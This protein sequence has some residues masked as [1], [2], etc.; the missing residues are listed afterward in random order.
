MS[1]SSLTLRVLM[2]ASMSALPERTA[3]ILRAIVGQYIARAA[4]VPS[5]SIARVAGLDVSS[6]TIR[7]EMARLEKDG[8][9][10]RPHTSAGSVPSDRG[11][12]FYVESLEDVELPLVQR[13][14]VEHVLHQVE[15][16]LEEWLSLTATLLANLVS[17]LAIVFVARP[18]KSRFKHLE[19]VSLQDDTALLVM[20]LHGAKVRQQLLTFPEPVTQ[21]ELTAM[22]ARLNQRL[23]GK[24]AEQI[25]GGS[26]LP[27]AEGHVLALVE[28]IMEAEDRRELGESY[29]DG[30]H[31]MLEQPEF[32]RG[33]RALTLVELVEQRNL[34]RDI[35]PRHLARQ[36]VQVVIGRENES[37]AVR[38]CSLVV[39]R[40]GLPDE[41]EGTLAVVG[42][43]RMPYAR[44]IA[45][46][47]Y[48]S[49]LLGRLIA[50]L[51]GREVPVARPPVVRPAAGAGE[52]ETA[53]PGAGWAS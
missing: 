4:P 24:T 26:G 47:D 36:G 34:L 33:Q 13:Y 18:R 42:P 49:W 15:T 7:N 11:Y 6:A 14:R 20:V 46:V 22:S 30:L 3:T 8:Y 32:A 21:A 50:R 53:G 10:I 23:E 52:G 45:A 25:G 9:I 35:L 37:E 17:N 48:M 51:Y 39:S 31:L 5:Q 27:G 29:L 19:L 1:V 2:E 28:E 41:A 12:R 40:Y 38:E 16:R 44:T 43:T